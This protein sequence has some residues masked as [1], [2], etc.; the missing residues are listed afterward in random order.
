MTSGCALRISGTLIAGV[1]AALAGLF[2][3]QPAYALDPDRALSQYVHD[4]WSRKEGLPSAVIW[5]VA[6]SSDG[7]LWLATQNGL[8]R[9]DGVHFDVFNSTN[10]A[11]FTTD[12][13]RA[14]LETAAGELWIG[15]YGGGVKRRTAGGFETLTAADGLAH[16]VVYDIFQSSDDAMWFATAAGASRYANG[17][18]TTYAAG[19]GMAHDRVFRIMEADDGTMWFATLVGGLS[20]YRNGEF[21]TFDVDAGLSSNQVH[22]LYR[23]PSGTVWVGTYGGSLYRIVEGEPEA[24]EMPEGMGGNGVQS[25]L[26]DRDGTLWI[27]TY[28]NGLV[29]Y[30]D[31]TFEAAGTDL[32]TDPYVFSMTEDQEGSLWIG[33]RDR[34]NRLRDGKFLVYGEPEGL[35]DATFVVAE[36]ARGGSIWVGTEGHGVE[37]IG[38][39]APIR[40]TTDNGLTSNNISA[41]TP[42]GKGGLWIGTF[43]G[44]VNHW[45]HGSVT[46]LGPEDGLASAHIFALARAADG[47][48]WVAADGG[49]SHV[50]DGRIE[51]TYTTDDGLADP[52]IRQIHVNGERIWLGTNGGGI[53]LLENGTVTNLTTADGL[54]SNIVYAFH[55]D[56]RG[57]LWIGTRDGGLSRYTDG[58]FA[59]IGIGQGLPQ[60]SVYAILPDDSG[61]LWLTG[62]GGVV[63]VKR[64]QLDGVAEGRIDRVQ[65]RLFG[66]ADGL[67]SSQ[68]AGG[69]QPAGIQS[70]GGDLWL[71]TSRGVA[72]FD[73]GELDFNSRPPPVYIEEVIVDGVA[74]PAR[75]TLTLPAGSGNLEIH[76]TG[77]S[78]VAPDR[79]DF[80][81]RLEGY[82]PEWQ[83][84]NDRRVAYYTGLPSGDYTF[85]VTASNND[86]LWNPDGA[87]LAISQSAFLYETPLFIGLCCL[88]ALF[89][90]WLAYRFMV[91]H[92]RTRQAQLERLVRERT[93]QLEMAL[94]KVE[95]I[96]RID[97]LTGVANRRYFDEMLERVWQRAVRDRRHV[98]LI[99]VDLD[100]FKELNDSQGHQAGD[101]CLRRIAELLGR[102]IRP[103]SDLLARYGGEE[104][105]ILAPD[106]DEAAVRDI[107]V[108]LRTAVEAAGIVRDPAAGQTMTI[109]AGYASTIPD[110]GRDVHN[111]LRQADAALYAAKHG[112]RNQTMGTD[113]D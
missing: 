64:E 100:H 46:R 88:V 58:E 26:E 34:L 27:G 12:D 85:H 36:A 67:R 19:D 18:F 90:A 73:P 76:Y 99:L 51:K 95:R 47:S 43:G 108:R 98:G 81:Y 35:T 112:G 92:W 62:A 61:N 109:S 44:G 66:S 39:G 29:R 106:A 52:L 111:L 84:V 38:D 33:T 40:L 9:F 96:S 103:D 22:E 75:D 16:N 79:V 37:R 71:P 56:E 72:V 107:A 87:R 21:T 11:E 65:A 113:L 53:S 55:R 48:L 3:V 105:V 91:R 15:T 69:F 82:D 94:D 41:L 2:T 28:N 70:T 97:G 32:L 30:R 6:Q 50:V 63:R 86:G 68:F 60:S 54:P 74:A 59:N 42:D 93:A 5:E 110:S 89:L 23:D 101:D 25:I 31:D 4:T 78:L 8:A 104:F 10:S 17:E 77:L 7:Y 13:V 1:M 57:I 49:V 83:R 45:N 102:N 24:V 14:I 20:R 80:R